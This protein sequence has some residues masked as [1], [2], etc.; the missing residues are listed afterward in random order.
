MDFRKTRLEF[1]IDLGVEGPPDVQGWVVPV[2]DLQ[3]AI[4]RLGPHED[5]VWM[6]VR[7]RETGDYVDP[8]RFALFIRK[9]EKGITWCWYG[10]DP[11]ITTED[12]GWFDDFP[13]IPPG[14]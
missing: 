14:S 6:S 5:G 3:M 4:A 9:G 11:G 12:D 8:A 7:D 1:P 2:A 10:G 13:P